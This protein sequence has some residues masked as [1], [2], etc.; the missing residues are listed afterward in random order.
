MPAKQDTIILDTR[1]LFTHICCS[2]IVETSV[3][4]Q[5]F[6]QFTS[7]C[8][9]ENE[10]NSGGVIKVAVQSKN[11]RMS[12]KWGQCFKS[13]SH[14]IQQLSNILSS[15]N[16]TA[17]LQMYNA[18]ITLNATVFQFL[19]SVDVQH[20]PSAVVTWIIPEPTESITFCWTY[21]LPV[22]KLFIRIQGRGIE[23]DNPIML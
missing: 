16:Q 1:M 3:L 12:T 8:I 22:W 23:E 21:I 11:V 17:I 9:L 13:T 15:S 6:V 2:S 18:N 10:I 20:Q 4:L 14:G 7:W 19:F 5:F